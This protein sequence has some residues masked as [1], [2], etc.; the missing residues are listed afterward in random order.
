MQKIA[1]SKAKPSA[2]M[3]NEN[4]NCNMLYGTFPARVPFTRRAAERC[5]RGAFLP[6]ACLPV[7]LPACLPVRLSAACLP[8]SPPSCQV[9]A[10][11]PACCQACLSCF[12]SYLF[13]LPT[14]QGSLIPDSFRPVP[15]KRMSGRGRP[16]SKI[17]DDDRIP[18]LA[19]KKRVTKKNLPRHAADVHR[20]GPKKLSQFVRNCVK[21]LERD[22]MRRRREER[23]REMANTAV[24]VSSDHEMEVDNDMSCRIERAEPSGSRGVGGSEGVAATG[25][26]ESFGSRGEGGSESVAATG[27][28]EPFGS[29]GEGRG[30]VGGCGRHRA[31]RA[32]WLS[33]GMHL[34]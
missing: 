12:F 23:E 4:V 28:A 27:R 21:E 30:R 5:A 26:A 33:C 31:G 34:L 9:P 8:A 18:C 22:V 6:A 17:R 7:R 15:A 19:C 25:R 10:R 14:C 2:S 32:V 13:R 24:G 1:R 29:R 11:L 3:N 16:K 20:V